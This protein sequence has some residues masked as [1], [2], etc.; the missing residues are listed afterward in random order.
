MNGPNTN[1]PDNK[2]SNAAE[3]PVRRA[4]ARLIGGEITDRANFP[5]PSW[6]AAL[7][8]RASRWT[9]RAVGWRVQAMI[10][11]EPRYVLI[12][13]PH[14]TNW[15]LAIALLM[16]GTLGLKLR[17]MGKASLFRQPFGFFMRWLG[18]IPVERKNRTGAVQRF[19]ALVE[20]YPRFSLAIAPEGT[21][22]DI[23]YWKTGF[24]H[25][26]LAAC[27]PIALGYC[28]YPSRVVGI[29]PTLHPSGDLIADFDHIVD[30][31]DGKVGKIP[32]KQ[33]AP[34]LSPTL[35]DALRQETVDFV[36]ETEPDAASGS[37]AEGGDSKLSR[38]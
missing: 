13:A 34:A 25:I 8:R 20:R 29:G 10:P 28:D 26:A 27:V 2:D 19:A 30:F 9:L 22:S 5:A 3:N 36:G 24:Y 7:R 37:E 12:G 6:L 15:D 17:W 23:P 11:R 31:Y 16:A 18:G 38:A 4:A 33:S 35:L 21:R 1:D 14:T 32:D